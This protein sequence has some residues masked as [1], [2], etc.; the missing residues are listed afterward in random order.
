MNGGLVLTFVGVLYVLNFSTFLFPFSEWMVKRHHSF[1][2]RILKTFI[3]FYLFAG[4]S[5][6]GFFMLFYITEFT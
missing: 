2:M 3:F 5:I 1:R 6:I 4:P